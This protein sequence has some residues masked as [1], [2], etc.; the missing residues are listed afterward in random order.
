LEYLFIVL[1]NQVENTNP[2]NNETVVCAKSQLS[3]K[4]GV[5]SDFVPFQTNLERNCVVF[6]AS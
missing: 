3:F 1:K 2:F 4:I 6:N 5:D